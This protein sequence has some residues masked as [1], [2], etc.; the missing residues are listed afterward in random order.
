MTEPVH[1]HD[2][3]ERELDGLFDL[4]RGVAPPLPEALAARMLADADAVIR[5]AVAV[6]PPAAAVTGGW[7]EVMAALGG[8]PALGGLAFVTVLGVGIGISQPDGLAALTPGLWGET[9]QFELSADADPIL[10]FEG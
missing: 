8:W 7:R 4:A 2:A 3:A 5:P 9:V 1:D 6:V 10:P